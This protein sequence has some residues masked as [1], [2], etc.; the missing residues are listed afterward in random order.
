M[1]ESSNMI[2]PDKTPVGRYSAI[3]NDVLEKVAGMDLTREERMVLN[4]IME[5][6]IGWE[7]TRTFSNESVRRVTHNIPIK[8]FED[9]TGLSTQDI[10]NALDNLEKRLIISRQGDDITFNHHLGQWV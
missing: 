5:D 3:G 7:S 1:R 2:Y 9:K 6:T 10:N 4:R 8:R